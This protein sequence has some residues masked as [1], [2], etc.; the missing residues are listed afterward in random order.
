MRIQDLIHHLEKEVPLAFQESYDNSG[1]IVGN[2]QWELTGVLIC[3]DST[4]EVV[5]EAIA[6]GC[7]LIVAHHPIIFQGLKQLTGAN[8]IQR[9]VVKAIRNDI[10]IYACHTNLDN[11]L[12]RGVNDKI[13][14]MIGVGN[15]Q[16]IQPK[17][18]FLAEK[19]D[20]DADLVGT[21]LI[22]TLK[23]PMNEMAFLEMLKNE[24]KVSCLKYTR[25]LGKEIQKVALCGGSGGFLLKHA[26]RLE[27]DIYISSDFKYHEFFNA[28]GRIII[29]DL[30]HYES[31]QFTIEVLYDIISDKMSTFAP[32]CTK[33]N[34][35][36]VNYL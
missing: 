2:A 32:H 11:V 34:T 22:G 35:N 16:P 29:A 24:M 36:P 33:H 13:A 1:L 31:E 21:G 14:K 4:E 7:N 8:Y 20:R 6:L 30:G 25:L 19:Y 3:L 28:D 15:V 9:T 27:A 23:E 26:M 5:E 10:A 17:S 12:Q 18:S